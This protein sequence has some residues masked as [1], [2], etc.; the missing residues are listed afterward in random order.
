MLPI[1]AIVGRPNTGKSTLFN[2][3]IGKRHA[4]ESEFPGTTRDRLFYECTIK[5]LSFLLVDTGGL[6]YDQ[7][8][9]IEA[10]VQSQTKLAIKDASL[11]VAVFDAKENLTADDYHV[12]ELLRKSN[13]K[14]IIV[15]NK[16]DN[17]RIQE[18]CANMYQIG[19]E[20]P[21]MIS[22]IHGFGI[23]YLQ[24]EIYKKL[25]L[26]GF[27][28]ISQAKNDGEL[29][30]LA[31]VG[32]PN[33]G[34]STLMNAFLKEEK[35][36]TSP[37]PG[38]TR[39]SI[40]HHLILPHQKYQL[41]DTAGIRS[42][43]SIKKG[44]EK[45][46]VIRALQSIYEADVVLWLIDVQEGLTNQDQHI[47]NYILDNYKGIIIVINKI[48]LIKEKNFQNKYLAYLQK[49]LPYLHFAPVVF[50]SALKKK[51]IFNLLSLAKEIFEN[52]KIKISN[53]DLR[54]FIK[55]ITLKHLPSKRGKQ[56]L[57]I[58]STKQTAICPPTIELKVNDPSLAHF[59]YRRYLENQLRAHYGFK[60]TAIKIKYV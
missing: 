5:D 40:Y 11:I 33:L 28:E 4:I 50:I 17:P 45:F 41:I 59:S 53:E 51:N 32:R 21:L 30:N 31:I 7:K 29:L 3:I 1:V 48:D 14:T 35:V 8:T 54:L 36:I 26:Q 58:L 39:D 24:R 60:G 25:L 18:N 49:K 2:R 56:I 23:D 15:I 6:E 34:K 55:K 46:S 47:A 16:C 37:H 27:K 43:G 19:F 9:D 12:M 20:N 38:T 42:R 22:S 57:K 52:R 10:D 44:I 13:K